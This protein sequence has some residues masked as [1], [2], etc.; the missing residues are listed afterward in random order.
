MTIH[1]DGGTPVRLRLVAALKD[2]IFQGEVLISESNF[3]RIFPGHQGYQFFLLDLPPA[4]SAGLRKPLQEALSDWGFNIESSQEHLAAYHRVENTYLSTF[5]S[6]GALG[7]VLGTLGLATVLLRNV[8]ERRQELGILRAVGYRN[9]TL[10]SV[11]LYE[12]L[13]LMCWGLAAGS[14]CAFLAIMPAL[15]SRGASFPFAA[16]G[17]ILISVLMAGLVSSVIAVI[18]AL[19]SPLLSALRSE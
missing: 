14:I 18:A 15:Q 1:G 5:Q 9:R 4:R 10:S 8:L 13:V 7:L 6:L 12:N 3:L 16:S 2:S 17:L 19:R 11:I